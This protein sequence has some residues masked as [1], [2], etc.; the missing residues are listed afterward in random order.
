MKSAFLAQSFHRN[1]VWLAL[2]W[3]FL[4]TLCYPVLSQPS[5]PVITSIRPEGTNVVVLVNV[6][7]GFQRITLESRTRFG[8]G[9][10]VPAAVTQTGGIGGT[11]TF[12]LPCARNFEML[13]VRA[14]SLQPLPPDFYTGSNSF[15]GPATNSSGPPV[16]GL[17]GEGLAPTQTP[18]GDPTRTVVESDIWELT[19]DTLYFFNQYRGLQVI[20]I[21]NPDA[22]TVVG[23]LDLPAAG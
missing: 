14:D 3:A 8:A 1:R 20:D 7:T 15:W 23:T 17:P 16:T 11:V 12:H 4:G 18:A 6:P 19:G 5:Q 13:R 22:A 21:G 2:A 10:W 9:A